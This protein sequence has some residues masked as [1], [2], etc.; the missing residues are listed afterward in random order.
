[1][2]ALKPTFLIV[3]VCTLLKEEMDVFPSS[4]CRKMESQ[5]LSPRL[6]G[7]C[8][9]Q[10]SVLETWSLQPTVTHSLAQL[11]FP[12]AF[13]GVFVKMSRKRRQ[14]SE[15]KCFFLGGCLSRPQSLDIFGSCHL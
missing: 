10:L 13:L 2:V 11:L 7:A 12:S 4:Q 9:L 14:R 3:F 8:P 15:S 1:M 6:G 5:A